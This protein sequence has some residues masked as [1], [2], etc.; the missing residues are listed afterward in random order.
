MDKNNILAELI[1]DYRRTHPKSEKYYAKTCRHLVGGGSHNLRLIAPFPFYDMTARGSRI[2][3]M[4]G[5]TYVDFW[6]GHFTNIL[7]H[8][9]PVVTDALKQCFENG[10]G[11]ITGFPGMH[12]EELAGLI[13]SRINAERIRFTTSGTLATMYAVML[14]RAH[15]GRSRVMKMGGGWHGAQPY[16]LKGVSKFENGFDFM[17]SEG[18]EPDM[19]SNILVTEFNN[20][21]DLEEKLEQDG[22][23]IACLVMELMVGAGGFIFA[24]PDYVRKVV[25]LTRKYGILLVIDEVVTG[26]RFH[27]GGLHVLYDITPDLCVFGKTIGGGMPI[28]ALAGR[29]D[30]LSLCGPNG[31][32][33]K[34]VKFDGGTFSAHPASML[35]GLSFL[36]HVLEFEDDIYPRIGRLGAAVRAE[37]ESIFNRC[38]FHVKCSG[39]G[40]V[41]TQN[42]SIVGVHFLRKDIPEITTPAHAWDPRVSDFEIR[43]KIFK[44]AMMEEGFYTFHG[45]G[46][47]SAAHT[48][49]D[50]QAS[51]ASAERIA[52][53]W[54]GQG[55]T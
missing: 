14:A 29:E 5:N 8:N 39:D 22:D 11:L 36:R 27:A 7:G 40:G 30:I 4:D 25:E 43:E 16:L 53:K 37:M 33:G 28:S 54:S 21:A 3:D 52:K 17:E 35:A 46:G 41:I 49:K 50:I 19:D 24:R 20:P 45:Y 15:T 12:Q 26:F 32:S 18:I 34:M 42:S 38:G 51:L 9:A 10:Q 23:S 2:T 31:D 47:I 44:L 13:L 48:E 55:E 6:Q 1:A